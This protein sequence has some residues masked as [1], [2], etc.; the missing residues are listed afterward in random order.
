MVTKFHLIQLPAAPGAD[1]LHRFFLFRDRV[2]AIFIPRTIGR[3]GW[4]QASSLTRIATTRCSFRSNRLTP[5][6]GPLCE[7]AQGGEI[8]GPHDWMYGSNRFHRGRQGSHEGKA[9]T[10]SDD[11]REQATS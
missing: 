7:I 1:A 11:T 5:D 9:S 2:A 10:N 8:L 4:T 3:E 6:P